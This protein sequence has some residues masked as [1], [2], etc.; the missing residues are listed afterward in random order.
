MVHNFQYDILEDTIDKIHTR[1]E[2][3]SSKQGKKKRDLH[4]SHLY[5]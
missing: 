5:M 4:H 3:V 2:L 1:K